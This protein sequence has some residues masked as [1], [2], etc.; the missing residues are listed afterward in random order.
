MLRA[1]PLLDVG[2]TIDQRTIVRF[3]KLRW[4]F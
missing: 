4:L 2:G 1:L 3:V